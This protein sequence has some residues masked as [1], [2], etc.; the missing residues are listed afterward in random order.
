MRS[1]CRDRADR[2][3][4]IGSAGPDLRGPKPESDS[5][6]SGRRLRGALRARIDPVRCDAT[7][8]ENARTPQ[9]RPAQPAA[10][11]WRAYADVSFAG[12]WRRTTPIP[13]GP[14]ETHP[15][16]LVR[17]VPFRGACLS[18]TLPAGRILWQRPA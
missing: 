12:R 1:A 14:D 8:E 2:N 5:L 17:I 13:S 16:E 9:T 18:P 7:P 6:E 4:L 10:A 3:S 15:R 11:I